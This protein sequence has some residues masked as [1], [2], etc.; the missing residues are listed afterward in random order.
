MALP[1]K[2]EITDGVLVVVLDDA[3]SVN[4]GFSDDCRQLVYAAVDDHPRPRVVIDLAAI[5][6]L[7]SSGVALLIGLKRRIEASGGMLALCGL[8]P[9]V[10]DLLVMMKLAPLFQCTADRA[11]AVELVRPQAAL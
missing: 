5:D 11:A 1:L 8:Q 7:S 10:T 2:S 6:F 3:K 4:D 9:Y